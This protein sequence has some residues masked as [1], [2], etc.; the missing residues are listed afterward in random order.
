MLFEDRMLSEKLLEPYRRGYFPAAARAAEWLPQAAEWFPRLDSRWLRPNQGTGAA[1]SGVLPRVGEAPPT[2]EAPTT[3]QAEPTAEATGPEGIGRRGE[4]SRHI[5]C[6]VDGRPG[7]ALRAL[8]A[9]RGDATV[10]PVTDGTLTAL[11]SDGPLR[12]RRPGSRDSSI[13]AMVNETAAR[14]HTVIPFSPGSTLATEADV[15]ELLQNT[16]TALGNVLRAIRG[17]IELGLLVRWNRERV[18]EE[19]EAENDEVRR[20]KERIAEGTGGAT[21]LDR[22]RLARVVEAALRGRAREY[23]LDVR[24]SLRRLNVAIREN[25][26]LHEDAIFGAALLVERSSEARLTRT[27]RR[28][29]RRHGGV[30]AFECTGPRPPSSF[31]N[32]KLRLER[33]G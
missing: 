5:H 29:S 1:D 25:Q 2:A 18:V 32:I 33:A 16:R 3:A 27:M 19:V 7:P 31:V 4:P 17:K 22:L 12:R 9:A 10:Y 14:E 15:L 21:Y 6:I 11:V 24:R 13:H 20:L 8:I 26:S 30:L 23:S 28:L